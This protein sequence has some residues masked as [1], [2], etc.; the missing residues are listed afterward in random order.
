VDRLAA[1]IGKA[2]QEP[3]TKK[4]Y[5]DIKVE[6]VGSSPEQFDK[7]FREQLKFNEEAIRRANIELR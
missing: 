2:L 3:T 6:A 7:F 5:T 4:R 1:E